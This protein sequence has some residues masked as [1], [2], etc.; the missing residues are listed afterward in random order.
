[1]VEQLTTISLKKIKL[2]GINVHYLIYLVEL[3]PCKNGQ[4]GF[5]EEYKVIRI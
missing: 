5:D 3:N 1:M 2:Y 4:I